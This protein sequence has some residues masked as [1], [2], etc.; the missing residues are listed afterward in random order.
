MISCRKQRQQQQQHRRQ[1]LPQLFPSALLLVT[2]C[3][4]FTAARVLAAS[5]AAAKANADDVVVPGHV[6]GIAG[7]VDPEA[8]T[9]VWRDDI[10][11]VIRVSVSEANFALMHNDTQPDVPTNITINDEPP[12]V[13]VGFSYKGNWNTW[14]SCW[15]KATRTVK[16]NKMSYAI[17]F[18][19]YDDA[20]EFHGLKKLNLNSGR[21]DASLLRDRLSY[22]VFTDAQVVSARAGFAL[23][24]INDEIKVCKQRKQHK[25]AGVP[26]F[27]SNIHIHTD[28]LICTYT[29]T[30]TL[31]TPHDQRI[32]SLTWLSAIQ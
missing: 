25:Q 3:L 28:T 31:A 6:P 24:Y 9:A 1:L 8:G 19:K 16:C 26:L 17:T 7:G 32:L 30:H 5:T 21:Q 29:Y 2:L 4:S 20:V 27:T 10:V 18:D 23:L 22:Q 15:D 12:F 13:N 14:W 11:H